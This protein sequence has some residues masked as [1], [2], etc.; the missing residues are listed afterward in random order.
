MN[1]CVIKE[2][3]STPTGYHGE[4]FNIYDKA[5]NQWHQTWVDNNGMLLNLWGQLKSNSMV[6][7]G[8]GKNQ[9]GQ[10]VRHKITWTPLVNGSVRQHWQMSQDHGVTWQTLF[11]GNYTQSSDH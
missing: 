8:T 7:T 5:T 6:L 1:G 11:D 3:Y 10:E 2:S 4:S 9:Q